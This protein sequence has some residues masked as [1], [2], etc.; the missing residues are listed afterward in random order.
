M[1]CTG[2]WIGARDRQAKDLS[3][4]GVYSE[5]PPKVAGRFNARNP[6]LYSFSV[7]ERRSKSDLATQPTKGTPSS[8]CATATAVPSLVKP[9]DPSCVACSAI[10]PPGIEVVGR[11]NGYGEGQ[12]RRFAT[13]IR[14]PAQTVG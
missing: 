9:P 12:W 8:G 5:R 2:R 3:P 4:G 11:A 1:I 6:A 7:A 10:G 14:K 13:R